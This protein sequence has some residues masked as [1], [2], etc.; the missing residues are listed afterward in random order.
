[1]VTHFE[2][3][4]AMSMATLSFDSVT[5]FK[6]TNNQPAFILGFQPMNL[7]NIEY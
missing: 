7:R 2:H 4:H 6:Y 5:I 3:I 1:M